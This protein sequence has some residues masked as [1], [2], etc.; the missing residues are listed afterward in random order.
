MKKRAAEA[1]ER[2]SWAAKLATEL[3]RMAEVK[4]KDV[5]D[6]P[7]GLTRMNGTNSKIENE[8][9]VNDLM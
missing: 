5:M 3:S 6:V 8:L 4:V 7:P 9:V 2:A 1:A